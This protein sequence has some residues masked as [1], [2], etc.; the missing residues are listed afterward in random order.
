[1]IVFPAIDIQD[2]KCVRLYQGDF[3]KVTV[4]G[5]PVEMAR[6]WEARGARYLHVVD[7]D[8]AREGELR[9]RAVI[10]EIAR[11]LKIPFQL[12]GGI[13]SLDRV[14]ELLDLGVT[15]AI[16]GT[17]AAVD[18]EFLESACERFPERVVLGLDARDGRVAIKGWTESVNLTPLDLA[19]RAAE[20]GVAAIIHT[21]IAKDGALQGP[22][23]EATAALA[24]AVKVPFIVSGGVS[25]LADVKAVKALEPAGVVGCISGRALYTGDLDFAEAQ[26]AAEA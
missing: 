25:S 26:A 23:L 24:R 8:G 16:I 19:R 21:D 1:M 15:R 9:H 17:R 6:S 3:D 4:Y 12:G 18:P 7:L 13:R 5:D 2:G 14:R 10:A 11:T 22:N 20:A